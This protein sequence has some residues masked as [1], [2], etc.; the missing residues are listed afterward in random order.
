MTRRFQIGA[1][2]NFVLSQ[3]AVLTGI[4]W[5]GVFAGDF[6]PDGNLR[7]NVDFQLRIYENS[8]GNIPDVANVLY[9]QKFDAG[10][11]GINDGTQ[12]QKTVIP[13]SQPDGGGAVLDYMLDLD[14]IHLGPGTYWLSIRAEMDFPERPRYFPRS[15]LG[16][17]VQ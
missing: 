11:A 1:Y 9:T 4:S 15:R 14:S 8:A 10:H 12:V 5:G 16:M 7:S 13:N 3:S 17:A 6:N 2:D